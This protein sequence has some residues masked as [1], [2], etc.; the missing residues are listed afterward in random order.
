MCAFAGAF[1]SDEEEAE[2][3]EDEADGASCFH[4][5]AGGATADGESSV[6]PGTDSEALLRL[7]AVLLLLLASLSLP[8]LSLLLCWFDKVEA[9]FACLPGL[10]GLLCAATVCAGASASR[11]SF[12]SVSVTF[13]KPGPDTLAVAASVTAAPDGEVTDSCDGNCLTSSAASVCACFEASACSE[14]RRTALSA[15]RSPHPAAAAEAAA[16][17]APEPSLRAVFDGGCDCLRRKEASDIA[18]AVPN[19]TATVPVSTVAPGA[20]VIFTSFEPPST[21]FAAG[22]LGLT[23]L[24][25]A[26][27]ES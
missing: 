4:F 17:A 20:S 16:A 24:Q 14:L 26:L 12:G 27:S 8:N 7:P 6:S 18:S 21:D 2:E 1:A 10:L 3:A 23:S 25:C 9:E 22:L 15:L 11:M 19:S 5:L 13:T